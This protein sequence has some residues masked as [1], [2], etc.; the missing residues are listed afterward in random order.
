VQNVR[1]DELCEAF[2]VNQSML[3]DVQEIAYRKGL[4]P[5][6]CGSAKGWNDRL[7]VFPEAFAS[8]KTAAR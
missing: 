1:S 3:S 7:P 8:G 6:S 4:I 5:H 2:G